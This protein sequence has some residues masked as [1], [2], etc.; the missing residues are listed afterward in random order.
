M[1]RLKPL[2]R[3]P[4]PLLSESNFM[5]FRIPLVFLLLLLTTT[6]CGGAPV[7]TMTIG[8]NFTVISYGS[9]T[10]HSGAIPADGN[11]SIGPGYFVEFVNGV[12]AIYNKTN[13]SRAD[14]KTDVDFWAA[15]GVA[16]D[17]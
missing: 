14:F 11:G 1:L 2:R 3:V 10:T 16:L 6:F 8:Q 13:G 7:P 15:A 5:V 17:A 12:F 9:T 4:R